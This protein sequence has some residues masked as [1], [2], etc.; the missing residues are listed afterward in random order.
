MNI[1]SRSAVAAML[2]A[3]A[4]AVPGQPACSSDGT[5]APAALLERFVNADCEGCWT[6]AKVREPKPGE[7]V[8]DWIVPGTRGDDAPLSAAARDD[9]LARLAALGRAVPA[10]DDLRHRQ[11]RGPPARLRVAHGLPFNGYLGASIELR[12]PGPGPLRTPVERNLVRNVLRV[13]WDARHGRQ[14]LFE[15]RPMNIPEGA[16]PERL[17][18]V[19]LLEDA[20]GRIRGIA[21]SRCAAPAGKG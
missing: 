18:V 12:Q 20:R 1:G 19:G 14:R 17:R 2:L 15:S 10:H 5:P 8:L 9:G 13:G 11:R 16:R 4:S 6:D 21:Q 7:V 3:A